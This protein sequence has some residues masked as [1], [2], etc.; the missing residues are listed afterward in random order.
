M[1]HRVYPQVHD[2]IRHPKFSIRLP[3]LWGALA[4]PA[5]HNRLV[6][7]RVVCGIC[8]ISF[9]DCA[10]NSESQA[11]VQEHAREVSIDSNA[12]DR[13]CYPGFPFHPPRWALWLSTA[14]IAIFSR[15]DRDS[16]NLYLCS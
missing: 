1:E 9:A 12:Y 8:Y 15:A 7:D 3:H 10:R 4:R 6:Q 2:D 13:L 16:G 14:V 11:I 5:C